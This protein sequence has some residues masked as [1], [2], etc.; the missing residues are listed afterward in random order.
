MNADTILAI[1][2]GRYKSAVG[3]RKL[4]MPCYG[5][6]KNRA[7]STRAGLRESPLDN[8][9]PDSATLPDSGQQPVADPAGVVLISVE[10]RQQYP[11][12]VRRPPEEWRKLEQTDRGGQP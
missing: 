8:T 10:L 5:V 7:R 4:V 6:L 1:D 2:R 11:V 12:L 3:M 9:R